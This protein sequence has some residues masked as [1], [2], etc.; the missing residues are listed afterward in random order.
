MD[1]VLDEVKRYS[2]EILVV[3]DGSSDGTGEILRRRGDVRIITR[4]KPRL[5]RRP[6]HRLRL[7][8]REGFEKIVTID[9]DGQHEPKRIPLFFESCTEEVDIVSGSRYLKHFAGDSLPP[10]KHAASTSKSPPRSIAV[11]A[12]N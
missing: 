12:M 11:W 1:R 2:R 5:W 9:C 10:I 7:R 4:R 3:D 8:P 6:A